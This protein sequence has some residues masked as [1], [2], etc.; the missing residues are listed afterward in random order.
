MGRDDNSARVIVCMGEL[1]V[2]FVAQETGVELARATTFTRSPGG[3]V[4]NVAVG[5]SRLGVSSRFV[6][7]VGSDPFG[8]FLRDTLT[9]EG[10]DTTPLRVSAEYP[11]AL[12]FVALDAERVPSFYLFGHP[13]ADQTLTED[14]VGA[15]ALAG[16]EFLHLGTVSLVREDTRR[17]TKKLLRLAQA[18]KTKVSFDP[19]FR[20]H[21]WKD[22]ALLRQLALEIAG[23]S[24]LVKLNESELL[25]LTGTAEPSAGARKLA[26][27][28]VEVVVVTLGPRGAYYYSRDGEG[29]S[30]GFPV[31][32]VDTTGAGD[33]FAAGLLAGLTGKPWPPSA[34]ELAAAVRLANAVGAIVTTAVGAMTALPARGEVEKFLARL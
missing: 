18:Q 12:V 22:H 23:E 6:G 4:A 30:P 29:D 24:A 2:D 26:A 13:S 17:A 15:A 25:F 20:L 9:K 16:A 27:L 7:K 3:A 28:G 14:E 11:T 10:V 32:A 1:L 21:M 33:G 8:G 34:E 31:A 5:L 19:N